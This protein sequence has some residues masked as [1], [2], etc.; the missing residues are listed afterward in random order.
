MIE[1]ALGVVIVVF[2]YITYNL[3][4]KVERLQDENGEL[5][6]SIEAHIQAID[7]TIQSMKTIDSKGGFE[8]DDEVGTVFEA[9]KT[10]LKLLEEIYASNR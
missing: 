10:E 8:S 2:S 5:F 1:I 9:L 3:L 4:R 7:L 6:A